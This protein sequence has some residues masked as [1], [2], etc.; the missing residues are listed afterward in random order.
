MITGVWESRK[1]DS[2]S[3]PANYLASEKN[4]KFVKWMVSGPNETALK[5]QAYGLN[6]PSS[7]IDLVSAANIED[8]NLVVKAAK[9]AVKPSN[10]AGA[11]KGAY[12]YAVLDEGTKARVNIGSSEPESTDSL[13]TR[14]TAL[15]SGGRPSFETIAGIESLADS[16]VDVSTPDGRA[17]TAKMAS[18][19]S[20]EFAYTATKG[21]MQRRLHDLTTTST[22]VLA[23]VANGG[24][25]KDLNLLADRLNTGNLPAP[26]ADGKIYSV[27]FGAN[28][29][30]DPSWRRALSWANVFNTTSV[31]KKNVGGENVPSITAAAPSGWDAALGKN[32]GGGNA[33]SAE[34][35]SVQPPGPVL[36]PSVAKIQMTFA[37]AAR[38]VYQSD[39]DFPRRQANG[40]NTQMHG[41]WG[42]YLQEDRSTAE[43]YPRFDSPFDY[44]LHMVYS[45]VIT[46][47]NP[48]NVPL[49]FENLRVEFVN[50]PFAF[51]VVKNGVDQTNK[52][53]PFSRMY[54]ATKNGGGNKRFGLTLTDQLLPG[55]VKVYSPNIPSGRTW[56]TEVGAG[57]SDKKFWDWGNRNLAD[58]RSGGGTELDTSLA[59]GV[60]GWNGPP[61]GYD[62]DFLAPGDTQAYEFETEGTGMS[63]KKVYRWDGIPLTK[64]DRL[65]VKFAPI[66]DNK[67]K[68][69]FS[70]EM[71]LDYDGSKLKRS[72][73]L[74][75]T[76]DNDSDLK[77]SFFGDNEQVDGD[78]IRWP[79]APDTVGTMDLFDRQTVSLGGI[80]NTKA[81]AIVSAYAKSTSG[82][83]EADGGEGLWAGKPYSF[84]NH[85]ATATL[86]NVSSGHPSHHSHELSLRRY[87][88]GL[89]A[90]GIQ[91]TSH[92]GRFITGQLAS[93]GR[94]FGTIYEIPLA[95]FQSLSALN[96]AQLAAG[97]S[98]PHF[99]APVGNSYAHPLLSTSNVSQTG[100]SGDQYLDHSFLLNA[101][102]YDSYYTSGFQKHGAGSAGGDG[103]AKADLIDEFVSSGTSAGTLASPLPDQHLGMFL[104]DGTTGDEAKTTLKSDDGYLEAAAHQLVN[105]AFNVNSISVDAWKAVLSSMSGA[106][107]TALAN[108]TSASGGTTLSE[109][110]LEAKPDP[111]G[112]RFSRFRLPNRQPDRE[113]QD[114][115]WGGSIDLDEAQLTALAEEIVRQVRAR[116][117]FL[118]MS[119]FVNRQLGSTGEK[120]LAGALQTAI[121]K[122][123][124]N[125]GVSAASDSGTEIAASDTAGL[126]LAT[127]DA[128]LGDSAQGAPGYLM[129]SDVLAVLG[130]TA[131]VRSDTFRIRAYGEAQD[132]DG[133]VLARA[134]CEAVVQRVPDF[135]DPVNKASTP[136]AGLN[137]TNQKFGRRFRQISMR[138]LSAEEI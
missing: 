72:S 75:F 19:G 57:N 80:A 74:L 126:N 22:G 55:E 65:F 82:G 117:P 87:P 1:L 114:G 28:L 35:S 73:T 2:T 9:V 5:A 109:E 94:S 58:G 137:P 111:K 31:V 115:F 132:K 39:G 13:A 110:P 38:D 69:E 47:H 3:T 133:N 135:V 107:A 26:Y 128:L 136:Q 25:K 53:V 61:V 93:T 99:S 96:S 129:Q 79:A 17:A 66:P 41:P 23:D 15:G 78:V 89:D 104:P 46:L 92:R 86:Q 44:L 7:S 130:N 127:P 12:A 124:I 63:G 119:E 29:P 125:A 103:K 48:Y 102:L 62:L 101:A 134:W 118:S 40:T 71:T 120:S 37:L 81:F 20:A 30:S 116:G 97:T 60:P 108:P 10:V 50:I 68:K 24:L 64:D 100:A 123:G 121:D 21:A 34:L 131:T 88:N 113:D 43:P 16:D 51:Q 83:T 14:T 106:Q 105:G 59:K 52:L 138:W 112:A 11:M 76:F 42:N 4:G 70:V 90:I 84:Q 49:T 98:L 122:S 77:N 54:A 18:L 91:G 45:P 8:P 67:L 36:L 6:N 27:A 85:T 33:A 56:R 95:P 32:A